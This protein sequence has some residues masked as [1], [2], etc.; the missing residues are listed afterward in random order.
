MKKL[1]VFISLLIS[2]TMFLGLTACNNDNDNGVT[3]P[4][5]YPYTVTFNTKGGSAVEPKNVEVV[6]YSPTSIKENHILEGW[7]FDDK[8]SVPVE[9]PLSV[10]SSFTVY[11][12]WKETL[13]SMTNRFDDFMFENGLKIEKS[14]PKNELNFSY[15]YSITSIGKAIHYIWKET[16][17]SS[18]TNNVYVETRSFNIRFDFGDLTTGYGSCSYSKQT[19]SGSCYSFY[20]FDAIKKIGNIYRMDLVNTGYTNTGIETLESYAANEMQSNFELVFS[21]LKM[22]VSSIGLFSYILDYNYSY[23]E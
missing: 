5:T 10:D 6:L 13:Q 17:D 21:D 2:L 12:K 19:N 3:P 9:F 11:A 23:Y 16:Y 14:I 22:E 15:E 18:T 8:F 20:E 4:E 1:S 7:Y